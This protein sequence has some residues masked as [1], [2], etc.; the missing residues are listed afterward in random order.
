MFLFFIF[1]LLWE[2]TFHEKLIIFY[3]IIQIY[4]SKDTME[5][6]KRLTHSISSLGIVAIKL[7]QWLQY[8]LKIH[9]EDKKQYTLLL[10]TLPLLQ[11]QCS[12]IKNDNLHDIVSK[13]SSIIKTVDDKI[14][15]SASIGQLY[16][17]T[18]HN[19]NPIII[20]IK[21]NGIDS[22]IV[23][24]E[25]IFQSIE[26]NYKSFPFQ[27]SHFFHSLRL[28][29]NFLSEAKNMQIF[30]KKYKRNPLIKIPKYYAGSHDCII[31]EFVPSHS[32][33]E[34][35]GVMSMEEKQYFTTLT[36]IFYQDNVFL[37]DI[38]HMDLHSGNWGVIQE[39]KKVVIYDY[40]WVLQKEEILEF[41]KFF[42]LAHINANQ[43]LQFFLKLYNLENNVKMQAFVQS[44]LDNSTINFV[45]G[46]KVII[47]LFPE[48][49]LKMDNF[50]L[51]VL[52]VCVFLSSLLEKKEIDANIQKQ[53]EDEIHFIEENQAFL[54]LGTLLKSS[55]DESNKL[56][57]KKWYE[58]IYR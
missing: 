58:E 37:K 43:C 12:K 52:S 15:T 14:Y 29:L 38:C 26:S 57:L 42:I 54:S 24:W 44:L 11:C 30:Y 35:K 21:N 32:F 22:D 19:D 4:W 47:R 41:K 40:G 33:N 49:N 23:R 17:A 10:N 6:R 45:E 3:I 34:L 46:L 31:M 55:R 16:R 39:E 8:F 5:N 50:V 13:F 53:L 28:Q 2:L 36:R 48:N 25:R 20:K 56:F 51:C 7:S 27:M 9:L 1:D 18:D